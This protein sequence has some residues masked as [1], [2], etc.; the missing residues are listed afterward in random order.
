MSVRKVSGIAFAVGLLVLIL[1]VDVQAKLDGKKVRA[2]TAN[3][4]K[5]CQPKTTPF[6]EIHEIIGKGK[7]TAEEKCFVTCAI[8]KGGLL[9]NNGEFQPDGIKKINEAMREF[10]DNPA[11]YKNI[12]EVI[13]AN[14]G[15]IEKPEKCDKGYAIAECSLKAFIDVHGNIF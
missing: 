8:T 13:I 6:D 10:D 3:I 15:G 5:A 11:E 4:A 12:D 14:C 7:P 2:F 1:A 9:S